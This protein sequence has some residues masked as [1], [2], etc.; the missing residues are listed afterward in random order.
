M[1]RRYI[2]L[3][4][5][6]LLLGII[7]ITSAQS[8]TLLAFLNGSGQLVV[9][10]GNGATRWIVT[11]PGQVVDE[12][13]G[14]AWTADGNLVFALRGAGIFEGDPSTQNIAQVEGDDALARAYLRG[15]GNRPNLAQ[16]QGVSSAG[17]FAFVWDTSG[18]TIVNL[19]SNAGFTLPLTG[20]NNSQSS[21][22]WSDNAPLVAYW[23]V[24][25]SNSTALS[26]VHAPSENSVTLASG[27]SV[28]LLPI[29]WQP[30][31]SNLIFR[32][33]TG[34]A[35]LADVGCVTSGCS[36]DPFESSVLVAPSSAN[37]IQATATHLYYVDGNQI[38]GVDLSCVDNNSCIES[39]QV[40][41]NNV[42]PLSLM[43]IQ[44]DH[45]AYTTY[46]NNPNNATDRTI[47]LLDL[48]CVPDC[49]AQPMINGAMA[50]LLSPDG[51]Y[52]M[53]DIV[54][55]GLNILDISGGSL[56]YLTDTIGGQLGTGLATARW[57]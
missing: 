44:G 10:S 37:H 4:V 49:Q 35:R 50:G 22:L 8:N 20:D 28:P 16:P 11:N 13:L 39:R 17:Q 31:T 2:W 48:T 34:D 30:N 52:L 40:L 56:V 51:R 38:V 1:K 47:V 53:V 7:P 57:R 24:D 19:R 43:H 26:V 32:S 12:A 6:V 45:L 18:Y 5:V 14:F 36:A 54:G 21:G 25:G 46:T 23:G 15:L 42:V 29:A 3:V 55:S 33:V 27:R 41:G 9:S